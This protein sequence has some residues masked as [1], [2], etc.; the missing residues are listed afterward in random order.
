M[1]N[2]VCFWVLLLSVTACTSLSRVERAE[3]DAKL[4]QAVENVLSERSYTITVSMM[5]PRRGQ[6]VNVTPDFSL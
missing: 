1:R 3:R 5:Y 6:S 2:S 4:A